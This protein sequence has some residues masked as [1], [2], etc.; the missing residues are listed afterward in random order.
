M[1]ETTGEEKFSVATPDGK[2]R[3]TKKKMQCLLQR[4][5]SEICQRHPVSS[6]IDQVSAI[7]RFWLRTNVSDY[8]C[9]PSNAIGSYRDVWNA[10]IASS[11]KRLT[12]LSGVMCNTSQ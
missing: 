12:T 2:S 6:S 11:R 3:N 8:Y 4:T 10:A 5:L 1:I 7:D 9:N